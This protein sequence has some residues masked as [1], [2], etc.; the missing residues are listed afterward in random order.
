MLEE[1]VLRLSHQDGHRRATSLAS[2]SSVAPSPVNMH[3][4][5]HTPVSMFNLH[6]HRATPLPNVPP[7]PASPNQSSLAISPSLSISPAPEPSPPPVPSPAPEKLS[8]LKSMS[9]KV[10]YHAPSHCSWKSP[11]ASASVQNRDKDKSKTRFS[12][13][14]TPSYKSPK[15]QFDALFSS[16]PKPKSTQLSGS[17]NNASYISRHM[18]AY[19]SPMPTNGAHV[20]SPS[21]SSLSALQMSSLYY[22]NLNSNLFDV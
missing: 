5:V 9:E 19:A 11:L 12:P 22:K 7:S 13:P 8:S 16:P 6:S 15:A 18:H 2:L 4:T 14:R 17:E 20:S 21:P 10:E 3:T 1:K